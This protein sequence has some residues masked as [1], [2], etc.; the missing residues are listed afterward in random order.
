MGIELIDVAVLGY[1]LAALVHVLFALY[2]GLGWRGG[3][4]G[5]ILILAVVMTAL[6]SLGCIAQIFV[7]LEWVA[8]LA[9]ALDA[10]RFAA[11]FAF[12]LT[13]LHT[14]APLRVRLFGS[15]A[16]ALLA[17]TLL[18]VLSGSFDVEPGFS[19]FPMLLGGLLAMAVFGLVLVE[20]IYRSL[21]SGSRWGLKPLCL[22]LA[23][24]YIFD[25]YFFADAFLFGRLDADVWSVRGVVMAMAM[26]LV[27]VS[28]A[29]SPS[30]TVKI[31]VSREMA[32]RSTALAISGLYLL[33]IAAAGYYVRYFGGTWGRAMQMTLL[34]GGLLLF[35]V[36]VFSG[37]QRAK[38]R[39]IVSKHLFPY[40][41]DYRVE[42]QKFTQ[43][44]SAAGDSLDLGQSVIKAV[45]DLVESPGGGLWLRDESGA[46][47]MHARLNHPGSAN[48]EPA[49][50][51]V[52]S[53]LDARE[54]VINLK[55]YSER[56][57]LYD[58]LELP[59]WILALQDPWLIVP[60]KC[61][62]ALIGFVVLSQPRTAFEVNWE[63][64][65]LLKSAQRQAASYLAQMIAAEALLEA[66]KFDSFNRMSAFVV[67]DLKNLVAQLSLM[68]K[69]AER[70]KDNPEFQADMLETVGHVEARMR[71]LMMQLQEKTSVN[72]P[73]TV[74]LVPLLNRVVEAKRVFGDRVSFLAG[75]DRPVF[76][77][78]HPERL[79]RVIG[80]VVQ[81]ALEA[82]RDGDKVTIS[83]EVVEGE[84]VLLNV[85][86]TGKGM[87]REFMRERLFKAFQS[88]KPSGMGIG[89]YETQQYLKEIGAGI[90]YESEEGKGTRVAITLPLTIHSRSEVEAAPDR[91]QGQA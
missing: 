72:P 64:L 91:A 19:L 6:W 69:N 24:A 86:D 42:W 39:V 84:K 11:W 81:N 70:H 71:G 10:L 33:L 89:V 52:C 61:R 12:L 21:P 67:H 68:L 3:R 38:L 82:C 4:A 51:A 1:G 2:L 59:E 35:G 31:A 37:T 43:A 29:R 25:L 16:V 23:A 55:E 9:T 54:W 44:L 50:G 18:V 56:P 87:S 76:V 32:F 46:F 28:A 13:L 30:W 8:Q 62:D 49:D 57:E 36:L 26:P 85:T 66:R 78:A 27:A 40:R 79:E 58:G 22:A 15:I 77:N 74:D 17:A 90:H 34:F 83:L 60:L 63:V 7:P 65:D 20:Q 45:A 73:R 47:R 80:H 53:F 5:G 88:T 41:Y 48:V 14:I 75:I